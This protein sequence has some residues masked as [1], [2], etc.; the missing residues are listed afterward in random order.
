MFF[1]FVVTLCLLTYGMQPKSEEV[2]QADET[3][4]LVAD[5]R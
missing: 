1:L 3:I 2:A 5:A 4:A